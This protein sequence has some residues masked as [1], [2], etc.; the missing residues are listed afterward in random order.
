MKNSTKG[1][2]IKTIGVL[3]CVLPPLAATCS[4]FPIWVNRSMEAT[5]SGT[6]II[7]AFFC[8]LPLIKYAKYIFRAP[9]IP[10][11][12]AIAYA[13]FFV[14]R[15]IIDEMLAVCLVGAI[16]NTIGIGVYFV[17]WFICRKPD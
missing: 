3:I 1:W 14:L 4:Q 10:L 17:G 8:C 13:L 11:F 9:A 16:S 5:I 6:F 2:L 12:W 7:L 15:S